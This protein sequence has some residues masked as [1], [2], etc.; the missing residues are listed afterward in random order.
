[1]DLQRAV[2]CAI[3]LALADDLPQHQAAEQLAKVSFREAWQ[4]AF[5]VP[6]IIWGF[7]A[8]GLRD[9]DY[10]ASER[11]IPELRALREGRAGPGYIFITLDAE[12]IQMLDATGQAHLSA[13]EGILT[14][15]MAHQPP[16]YEQISA[17]IEAY[18]AWRLQQDPHLLQVYALN[19]AWAIIARTDVFWLPRFGYYPP[20]AKWSIG[21]TVVKN[22]Q[23]RPSSSGRAG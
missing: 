11:R 1:M 3:D 21:D 17:S 13:A 4:H 8:M 10:L 2:L 6:S 15:L 7:V 14:A 5:D 9:P 20:I 23:C 16:P 19:Q 12:G 22:P 18:M